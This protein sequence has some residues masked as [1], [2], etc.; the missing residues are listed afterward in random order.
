[1]HTQPVNLLHTLKQISFRRIPLVDTNFMPFDERKVDWT[2]VLETAKSLRLRDGSS[3][4]RSMTYGAKLEAGTFGVYTG[5]TRH[6]DIAASLLTERAL[7]TCLHEF[8]HSLLHY[9][10]AGD[11]ARENE[12][13]LE[14]EADVTADL[15][16]MMMGYAPRR[17][18]QNTL[19]N[20][21]N[22]GDIAAFFHFAGDVCL[23]AAQQIYLAWAKN[24]KKDSLALAS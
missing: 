19:H 1:M 4:V 16:L 3:A 18:T 9:D 20:L 14:C 5:Y 6:V 2:Q 21:G 24:D 11:T 12:A 8:A 7:A 22:M 13:W 23:E 15:V 17:Y 10:V